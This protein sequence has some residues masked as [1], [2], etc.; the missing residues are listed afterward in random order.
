MAKSVNIRKID[1]GF[2]IAGTDMLDYDAFGDYATYTSP[3]TNEVFAGSAEQIGPLVEAFF[4][5]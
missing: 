3:K 1:N 5:A 4:N 2:I